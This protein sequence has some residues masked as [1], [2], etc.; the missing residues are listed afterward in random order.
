MRVRKASGNLLNGKQSGKRRSGRQKQ[1]KDMK[2][3]MH[4][5]NDTSAFLRVWGMCKEDSTIIKSQN[6]RHDAAGNRFDLVLGDAGVV[7]ELFSST[8]VLSSV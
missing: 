3:R 6:V 4:R 7:D 8:Q 5:E 1:N 2:R